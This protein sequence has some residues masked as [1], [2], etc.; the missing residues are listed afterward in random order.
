MG[1][2]CDGRA[3]EKAG[4][5]VTEAELQQQ[6]RLLST[7]N[8][9]LFRF[10]CG[11]FELKDGR[12]IT[13]GVPGMSDLQGW[14]SVVI[15]PDLVGQRVAIYTALEIKAPGNRTEKERLKKQLA[16]IATVKEHG[17]IA[18]M[19]ESVEQAMEVLK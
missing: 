6:I 8:V 1:G 2:A 12:R 13:V 5:R 3:R 11:H 18:G 4:G 15:T 17:G 10:Q 19:V 14:K 16:F 7:G 9:R